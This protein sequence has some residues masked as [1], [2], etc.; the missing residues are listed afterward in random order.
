MKLVQKIGQVTIGAASEHGGESA[1]IT[2]AANYL[3]NDMSSYEGNVGG[4]NILLEYDSIETG[5]DGG[6]FNG[7]AMRWIGNANSHGLISA[8]VLAWP[9]VN[10]N[11]AWAERNSSGQSWDNWMT[12]T[13]SSGL[14]SWDCSS[15]L[16]GMLDIFRQP[17][18]GN[19]VIGLGV[20]AGA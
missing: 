18:D 7:I 3:M 6:G 5:K 12:S 9:Q 15:T 20:L 4:Y 16:V 19:E 1:M 17:V 10:I 14:Y 8:A 13:P 11:Q 2:N